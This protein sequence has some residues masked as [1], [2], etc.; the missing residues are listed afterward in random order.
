L[1]ITYDDTIPEFKWWI[2]WQHTRDHQ[3][4]YDFNRKVFAWAKERD[5]PIKGRSIFHL[6]TSKRYLGFKTEYDALTFILV[7]SSD[8]I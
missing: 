6:D 8:L 7:W 1:N 2:I 5:M 3:E 4:Q